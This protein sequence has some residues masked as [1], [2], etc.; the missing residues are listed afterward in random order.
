MP[1]PHE[2]RLPPITTA[3]AESDTRKCQQVANALKSVARISVVGCAV[4]SKEALELF[5]ECQPN[6]AIVSAQLEDGPLH[7]YHVVRELRAAQPATRAV[8]LLGSRSQELVTDAFRC[9]A[10]GV[11][12]RDESLGT[13]VKCIQAVRR[14]QV[15]V[16]GENLRHVIDA[17][18]EARPF[19]PQSNRGTDML[20][21]RETE[22]V[23]LVAEGL[24]NRE[25]STELKLSEHTV[26][27]YLF[28]VFDKL[29]VSTRVELLLYCFYQ[30]QRVVSAA[31]RSASQD[32]GTA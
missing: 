15:W 10:Q 4:R 25:I 3:I 28:R 23:Q 19:Q 24:T 32:A 2:R 20:S 27:N 13:L 12:F 22:V 29:G 21:K 5:A 17:L 26:R 6:V 18:G 30:R 8:M 11:V 31:L 1:E 9:G 16:N 14:G 7:G